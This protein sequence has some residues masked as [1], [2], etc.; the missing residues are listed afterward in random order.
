MCFARALSMLARQLFPDVIQGCYVEG[1]IRDVLEKEPDQE[2]PNLIV[3]PTITQEQVQLLQKLING[4]EEYKQKLFN[5]F[6]VTNFSELPVAQW[7]RIL[8][9]LKRHA[10]TQYQPQVVGA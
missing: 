1:E 3:N 7:D 9:T 10:D 6:K 5:F 2:M 4:D 8:A